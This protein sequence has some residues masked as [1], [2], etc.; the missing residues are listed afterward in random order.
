[1]PTVVRLSVSPVKGLKLE[2]PGVI[3]VSA[4]GIRGD[5]AFYMID[6]EGRM[7][8]G[9]LLGALVQIEA[10]YD[11]EA[12]RLELRIPAVLAGSGESG[13]VAAGDALALGAAVETSFYGRPVAGRIVEGPFAEA[14]SQVAGQPV[15]LVRADR[16]SDA[17]D[18]LPLTVLSR[19]SC[20]ELARRSGDLRLADDR[21]FRMLILLDGC[22]P[23]EEDTW[24][25]RH[26]QIGAAASGG[27][28]AGAVIRVGS[29]V[30]RCVIT[31]QSPDTGLTD[32]DT[33]KAI[34]AYR[35]APE[36]RISFGMYAEVVEPG[37]IA[38]GDPVSVL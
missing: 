16:P 20:D 25:G 37:R 8:N 27:A 21:R 17:C 26:V 33:L 2:H 28:P 13:A 18:L 23:H 1:M 9:K 29:D 7:L 24:A 30:G 6:L 38:V 31:A 15:R 12:E 36:G 34:A 5:R 19:A 32:A 22:T 3:E 11:T 14:L 10:R 4:D 35:G